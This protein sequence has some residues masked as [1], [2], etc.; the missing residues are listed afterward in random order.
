MLN[1]VL[2]GFTEKD[3]PAIYRVIDRTGKMRVIKVK[4]DHEALAA[5]EQ[6]VTVAVITLWSS[7][8]TAERL[9]LISKLAK[10][11]IPA[12]HVLS[13]NVPAEFAVST[14]EAGASDC[15]GIEAIGRRLAPLLNMFFQRSQLIEQELDHKAES[16]IDDGLAFNSP[17][18]K[19]LLGRLSRV[20]PLSS[21]ILLTGETGVGKST[22]ARWIHQQSA[23]SRQPFVDVPCAALPTNLIESELFG[24]VRGSFTSADRDHIGKFAVA[25]KGTLLLDEVDCLPLE[26]QGKLLRAVERREFERVGST[27]TQTFDARLV[28]AS[29]RPLEIEVAE[30]RFRSDLFYRL[31][32]MSFRI[33]PLRSR[34]GAIERL[35]TTFC[36][37]FALQHGRNVTNISPSAMA[38][39]HEYSWPGNVR[40]LRN[41]MDYAV[42]ISA[43]HTIQWG[44][45]PESIR[46]PTSNANH[47]S[48]NGAVPLAADEGRRRGNQFVAAR[49]VAERELLI[50]TLIKNNNNRSKTAAALGVSRVTLYKLLAKLDIRGS[51]F[52]NSLDNATP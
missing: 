27:V 17:E 21:T 36:A 13:A 44:D 1:L 51:A 15:F 34:L 30:G 6:G 31:G 20:A 38:I 10:L 18:M 25:G 49:Q 5:T 2:S 24:H 14:I 52:A 39:L 42:A 47:P 46:K 48:F 45:L 35:A 32:V 28:V 12:I 41:A 22:L 8:P 9:E 4:S 16:L 33:P 50:E 3:L 7:R 23:R 11:K 26:V 37:Q 29:N 19:E 40:E 43:G